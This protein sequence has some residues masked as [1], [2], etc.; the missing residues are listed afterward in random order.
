MTGHEDLIQA[1]LAGRRPGQ[2]VLV[3]LTQRRSAFVAELPVGESLQAQGVALLTVAPGEAFDR[4]D[5]R[6]LIGLPV[7]VVAYSDEPDERSVRALSAAC[8]RAGASKV[9]GLQCD[10][11]STREV[12]A[13]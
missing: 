4:L 10:Y 6:C 1:R 13:A 8:L 3:E 11:G 12:F 7:V 9:T 2:G 5:L